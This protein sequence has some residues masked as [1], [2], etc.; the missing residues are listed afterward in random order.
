[1]A[2]GGGVSDGP[3]QN[4]LYMDENFKKKRNKNKNK[5][6]E[7]QKSINFREIRGQ[8]FTKDKWPSM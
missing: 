4:T 2:V 1:M 8:S 6:E 3:D 7:N 5:S